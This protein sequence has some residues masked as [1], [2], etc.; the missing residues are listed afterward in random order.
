VKQDAR[1]AQPHAGNFA[2]L[3]PV[4]QRAA[5]DWQPRQQLLLVNEASLD[6]RCLVLFSTS[7]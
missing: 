4:E 6:C 5:R 7:V 2:G 3:A 1:P